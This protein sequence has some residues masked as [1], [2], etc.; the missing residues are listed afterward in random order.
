MAGIEW[1]H[2]GT[3][4]PG[5]RCSR[6]CRASRQTRTVWGVCGPALKPRRFWEGL[7]G[8]RPWSP[9]PPLAGEHRP[10]GMKRGAWGNVAHGGTV[11]PPRHRKGGAGNP[12]PKGRR[13]PVLSQPS[14][15]TS[16]LERNSRLITSQLKTQKTG[17]TR[18][19]PANYATTNA[20][21]STT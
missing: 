3:L 8:D 11:N 13:A 4:S 2:A 20:N 5:K 6:R 10:S 17:H 7:L 1:T 16:S 18:C 21:R 12:P 15:Y 19:R 9:I 14:L